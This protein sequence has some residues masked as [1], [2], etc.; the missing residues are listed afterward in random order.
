M[1][2]TDPDCLDCHG[3]GRV[4]YCWQLTSTWEI[5][6]FEYDCPRCKRLGLLKEEE[7]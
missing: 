3:T 7:E 1:L 4:T 2:S 6:H 5:G